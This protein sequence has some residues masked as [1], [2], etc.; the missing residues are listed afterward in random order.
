MSMVI[1]PQQLYVAADYA[2][3][4]AE[5]LAHNIEFDLRACGL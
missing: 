3:Q 1:Q 5:C 4:V 2:M